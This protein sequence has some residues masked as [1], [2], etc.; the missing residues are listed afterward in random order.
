MCCIGCVCMCV[1]NVGAV[2]VLGSVCGAVRGG[3]S[4]LRGSASCGGNVFK[5]CA[6]PFVGCDYVL[7]QS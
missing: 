6:V 5:L 3:G 7:Q 1:N 2:C 4:G